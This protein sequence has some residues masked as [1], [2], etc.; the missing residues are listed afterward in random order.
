M[1]T[2]TIL[3]PERV[4]FA[5]QALST[6]LSRALGCA[7][8]DDGGEPGTRAQLLRHFQLLPRT[9]PV[10]A[11]SRQ[12]DV[13]DAAHA[14]WLRADPAWVRPDINGARLFGYGE[15]L[16]LTQADVDALLP[17]LRPMF[18]DSGFPLDAPAPARWYLRLPRE[19][20]LPVFTEPEVA[21]GTDLLEHLVDSDGS[22]DRRRWRALLSEAQ[23]V[24]HNH[25]WNAQRTAAGKPPVNSLW[26]WGGGVLPDHVACAHAAVHSHDALLRGLAMAAKV[27]VANA[28]EPFELPS[29]HTDVLLDLRDIRDPM[30]IIQAW[31]TPA[32]AAITGGGLA[33]LQLDFGDGAVWRVTR[34]QRWRFWNRPLRQIAPVR[35]EHLPE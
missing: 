12:A 16:Q 1:A 15:G 20:K 23:V 19:V 18:G 32:T 6:P 28:P 7:D 14:A 10:A 2:A 35:R 3:L 30:R 31:L 21:L 9:W 22:N 29:P 24:L 11:L 34:K 13:G 4:H 27:E 33:R 17:A 26:F 5:G 8:H 25:P